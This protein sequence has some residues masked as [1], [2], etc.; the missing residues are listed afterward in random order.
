MEH[1][2]REASLGELGV[3]HVVQGG[4]HGCA[5]DADRLT[6]LLDLQRRK[7]GGPLCHSGVD[8]LSGAHPAFSTAVCRVVSPRWVA[9][10]LLERGPVGVIAHAHHAPLL[11]AVALEYAPGGTLLGVVAHRLH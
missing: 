11:V 2:E 1:L 7:A 6:G 10:G 4:Q 5:G 8:C 9:H 3:G